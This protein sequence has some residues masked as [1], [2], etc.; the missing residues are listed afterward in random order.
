MAV[1]VPIKAD[2]DAL[3]AR[4][5]G[6]SD[7]LGALEAIHQVP[8]TPA[9]APE[10]TPAPSPSPPPGDGPFARLGASFAPAWALPDYA[11]PPAEALDRADFG[12]TGEWLDEC[13]RQGKP[14]KI[15]PGRYTLN[16]RTQHRASIYGYGDTMPVLVGTG[17]GIYLGASGLTFQGLR[18]EGFAY[19]IVSLD[20]WDDWNSF[21]TSSNWNNRLLGAARRGQDPAR[22]HNADLT[23][24]D[25]LDCEFDGVGVAVSIIR[26]SHHV[27]DIRV[28]RCHSR[29][30]LGFLYVGAHDFGSIDAWGNTHQDHAQGSAKGQNVGTLY[31]IGTN[32]TDSIGS[33]GLVRLAHFEA[34]RITSTHTHAKKN[35]STVFDVRDCRF[36]ITDFV[37]EDCTNSAGH[38]DAQMG[39]AK[40][41]G[42]IARWRAKRCGAV[43]V[44]DDNIGS[45]GQFL[46]LK[47]GDGPTIVEDFEADHGGMAGQ[48]IL[49]S[50]DSLFRRGVIRGSRAAASKYR[51]ATIQSYSGGPVVVEDVEM[52]DWDSR[53]AIQGE[54]NV[55]AR[56]VTVDTD[57][58]DIFDGV[59]VEG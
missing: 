13:E 2:F 14:G 59:T 10:P 9:P 37:A 56:R 24:L 19:A 21:G 44:D 47:G 39:Y 51:D 1:E 29:D 30:G 7:R 48:A 8:D 58:T 42:L 17:T 4:V 53:W 55:T 33:N 27:D 16:T 34:R 15:G 41:K 36:E 20:D 22:A 57:R 5:A 40:G 3:A 46:T 50:H 12:S 35:G 43:Q 54:G 18:F 28:G 23:G 45:E 52:P 26:Q 31:M 25:V 32:R 11:G 49:S 6:L 38:P